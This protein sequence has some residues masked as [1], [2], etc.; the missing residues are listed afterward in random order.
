VSW[1]LDHVQLAIPAGSE[2]LCDDFYVGL[3]GFKTL[4]KPPILAARGGR[5]YQR[6]EAVVHLGVEEDFLPAKKAHP[7]LVIDYYE[8]LMARLE[9]AGVVVRPD[10]S[11]PGVRRCHVEDPVGNRIELIDSGWVA[12]APM[13]SD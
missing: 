4:E 6:D 5:W 13:S 7:A 2:E 3:L 11:I 9:Q 8:G 12:Y 10:E 1:R